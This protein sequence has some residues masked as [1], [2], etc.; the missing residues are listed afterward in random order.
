MEVPP[1]QVEAALLQ[2]PQSNNDARKEAEQF[3]LRLLKKPQSVSIMLHQ[4]L[5]SAHRTVRCLVACFGPQE[6][7]KR[8]CVARCFVSRAGSPQPPPPPPP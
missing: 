4:S 7:R 1:A 3:L 5:H 6:R 2:L 8:A